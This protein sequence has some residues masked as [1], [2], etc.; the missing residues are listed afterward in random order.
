MIYLSPD[1]LRSWVRLFFSAKLQDFLRLILGG[2][3]RIR[4]I[5]VSKDVRLIAQ[6][7]KLNFDVQN[8][9]R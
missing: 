5:D 6:R 2:N 1:M 8:I 4:S 3:E 7:Y 9:F